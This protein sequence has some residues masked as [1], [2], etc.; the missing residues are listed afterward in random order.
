MNTHNGVKELGI[1]PVD[2]EVQYPSIFEY[3]SQF[4]PKIDKRS[5]RGNHWSNLRNCAYLKDFEKEKM[6][7]AE[8]MRVH[9]N[10]LSNFP[11][12]G[13]DDESF[14]CDKTT[15]IATGEQIKYLL[16]VLNSSHQDGT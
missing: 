14:Y 11:R 3:L 4:L 9:K 7:Y 12:F 16:G 10:D 1:P 6:I 13:F 5:D 15:F 8:T 2:V